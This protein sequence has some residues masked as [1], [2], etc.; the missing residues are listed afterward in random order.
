MDGILNRIKNSQAHV[1]TI[2]IQREIWPLEIEKGLISYTV[3]TLDLILSSCL[4]PI[5]P[6]S[7]LLPRLLE[8]HNLKKWCWEK[9][10]QLA[11]GMS[12][13]QFSGV[14]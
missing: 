3:V 2:S 14:F 12:V 4:M 7:Q 1:M 10:R 5:I 8:I 13:L 6:L 9:E 11:K